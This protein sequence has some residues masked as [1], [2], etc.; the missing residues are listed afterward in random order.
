M[1]IPSYRNARTHLE[2]GH[3]KVRGPATGFIFCFLFQ[4]MTND[5]FPMARADLIVH[6]MLRKKKEC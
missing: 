1:D 2:T 5:I 6:K 3:D 4:F